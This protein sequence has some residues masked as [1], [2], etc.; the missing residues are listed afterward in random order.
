M[1][2]S[3]KMETTTKINSFT[4]KINQYERNITSFI[5]MAKTNL[6]L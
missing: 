5:A 2:K 6:G 1:F 4:I 3:K